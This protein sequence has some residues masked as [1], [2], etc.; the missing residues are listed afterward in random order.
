MKSLLS[1]KHYK[2]MKSIYVGID[3]S[4]NTLDFCVRSSGV[5]SFHKIGNKTKSIRKLLKSIAKIDSKAFI[6]MEN[7][8]YYNYNLYQTLKDF[9][10]NVYV[11][12]PKHIKRSI[13]LVRGKN[14]KVDAK[15][16]AIFIERNH[17]DFECWEPCSEAIRSLKILMG[18]RRSKIKQRKGIKQQMADLKDIVFNGST[19]KLIK[20]NQS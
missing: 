10:F 1:T 6:A 7:T 4:K 11:I 18:Q 3:I 2:V 20:I 8:G 19:R 14:D 15:R 17:Q 9:D 5:A 13:G 16:I 12:D